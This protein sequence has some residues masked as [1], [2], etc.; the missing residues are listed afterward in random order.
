MGLQAACGRP[1]KLSPKAAFSS[2][3]KQHFSRPLL[4]VAGM[5]GTLVINLPSDHKG[6]VLVVRHNGK[7]CVY[8][9]SLLGAPDAGVSYVAFYAD[10]EHEVKPVTHGYR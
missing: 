3:P 7:Q 6:G 10:C 8:G 2:Q 1:W 4:Q 9:P 5:F